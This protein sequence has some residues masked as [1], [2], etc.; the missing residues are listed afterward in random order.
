MFT[1]YALADRL[2]KTVQELGEITE[3][4]FTGWVQYLEIRSESE[5]GDSRRN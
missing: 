1:M 5:H 3:E 4:E 2:H